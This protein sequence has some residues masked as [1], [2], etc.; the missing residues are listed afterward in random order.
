[1]SYWLD[2]AKSLPCGRSVRVHCPDCTKKDRSQIISHSDKGYSAYCFRCGSDS[3]RFKP[4]GV[5]SLSE[6]IRH[7]KEL[8][9]YINDI[10]EMALPDDFTLDIP[11]IGLR[12]LLQAGVSAP[13][14][15]HY[16]FGWSE[17][18]ARVVMPVFDG[19]HRLRTT[20]SRAV[21]PDQK[22]KYMNKR[23]GDMT[24]VAFYSDDA[25][26]LGDPLCEG[27]VIT[28]DILSCVRTGRLLPS[29]STLGTNLSD[30]LAVGGL[31]RLGAPAYIWYD[32]DE[33]GINGARKARKTLTLLGV[34]CKIIKTELDPKEYNNDE[35]RDIITTYT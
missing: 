25:L 35:I 21:Y 31:R 16:Q 18:M 14:A 4:H 26:L 8:D 5:R 34:P 7:R 2:I 20:Q 6:L 1:M 3:R 28:E 11:P 12:W 10:G 29:V 30:K 15:K 9:D 17:K 24:S 22:P 27:Y 33:A 19:G 23:S 32:G 13:V